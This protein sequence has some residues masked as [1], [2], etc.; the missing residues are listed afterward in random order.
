[1][2]DD[3][4]VPRSRLRGKALVLGFGAVVVASAAVTIGLWV[5]APESSPGLTDAPSSAPLSID[6]AA[7]LPYFCG[8]GEVFDIRS[9]SGPANAELGPDPAG[10]A[11]PPL[12]RSL[13]LSAQHWWR[14]YRS[15][16]TAEFLG[17]T[18]A[19]TYEYVVTQFKNGSWGFKGLGDCLIKYLAQGL[20]TLSWW[21]ERAPLWF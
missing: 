15:G 10:L 4:D 18:P 5:R 8:N 9:L 16:T 20:S 1:M 6:L 2:S 12:A 17:R 21:S 3:P 14:V 13:G 7:G 19:G 11:V